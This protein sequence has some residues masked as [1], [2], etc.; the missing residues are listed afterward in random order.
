MRVQVDKADDGTFR[1]AGGLH[2]LSR[3]TS[4]TRTAIRRLVNQATLDAVN[5][6]ADIVATTE[7]GE[8]VANN[9]M[10]IEDLKAEWIRKPVVRLVQAVGVLSSDPLNNRSIGRGMVKRRL[11]RVAARAAEVADLDGFLSCFSCEMLS[12]VWLPVVR[13]SVEAAAH[14][15]VALTADTDA[16]SA[17]ACDRYESLRQQ[18][19]AE[20]YVFLAAAP[21]LDPDEL[22]I[23]MPTHE[24]YL[25]ELF[26]ID[27]KDL[28]DMKSRTTSVFIDLIRRSGLDPR[29]LIETR[30]AFLGSLDFSDDEFVRA[31]SFLAFR[32]ADSPFP[33]MAHRSLQLAARLLTDADIADQQ[34]TRALVT[35]FFR[36]EASWI[37]ASAPAYENAK[38][39][40]LHAQD[41]PAIVEALR[42]L[43]EG[44]LRPYGSL[45][46]AVAA[47]RAGSVPVIPLVVAPTLGALEQRLDPERSAIEAFILPLICREW[48][49][50]DA[51]AQATVGPTGQLIL[52]QD[53]GSVEE[54]GANHV[55]AGTEMLRSALDGIDAAVNIF[56]MTKAVP[57]SPLDRE[58]AQ[59]SKEM[60]RNLVREAAHRAGQ[61]EVVN[62]A[63]SQDRLEIT[64]VKPASR[65]ELETM[66][67]VI[68]RMTWGQYREVSA[69][70]KKGRILANVVRLDPEPAHPFFLTYLRAGS[71]P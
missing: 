14:L 53:D 52:K 9:W 11:E 59:F 25:G 60:I 51:H 45:I 56:F 15:Q 16:V 22:D 57:S 35:S 30:F 67:V 12:D 4:A 36:K 71:R 7:P 70:N 55:F 68:G 61:E 8:A 47:I 29:A 24:G 54:A 33:L 6:A 39:R 26:G 10:T 20:L 2:P 27:R 65:S 3:P 37:V 18:F 58:V 66:L 38:Q 64:L 43:S 32:L 50:A 5:R 63:V 42:S 40:Y 21:Y 69:V 62:V 17:E 49:N 46:A 34:S 13:A 23:T 31:Y 48:R 41:L 44:V 1:M 28:R 19:E